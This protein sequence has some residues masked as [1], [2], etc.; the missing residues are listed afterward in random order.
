MEE[1]YLRA[2]RWGKQYDNTL[3]QN[4]KFS[5]NTLIIGEII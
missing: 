4:D 2:F 1:D 5:K 3:K